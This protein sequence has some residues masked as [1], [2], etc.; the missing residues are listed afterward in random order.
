MLA[1]SR[2]EVV[3][4][5]HEALVFQTESE[6]ATR[7]ETDSGLLAEK[8]DEIVHLGREGFVAKTGDEAAPFEEPVGILFP[9]T[10]DE[11]FDIRLVVCSVLEAWQQSAGTEET[12]CDRLVECGGIRMCFC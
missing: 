3:D 12:E 6:A 8:G 2:D 11:L 1:K 5:I 4:I 10:S 9:E 7:E